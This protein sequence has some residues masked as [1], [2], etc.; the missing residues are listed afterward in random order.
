MINNLV[1]QY[2]TKSKIR[3]ALLLIIKE[4]KADKKEKK[5]KEGKKLSNHGK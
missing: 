4:S 5:S 3:F 1:L 2:V